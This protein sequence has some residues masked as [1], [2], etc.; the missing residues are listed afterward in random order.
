MVPERIHRLI[1]FTRFVPEKGAG[2]ISKL[3]NNL[4]A[5]TKY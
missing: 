5:V 4:T 1:N 3:L 2:S